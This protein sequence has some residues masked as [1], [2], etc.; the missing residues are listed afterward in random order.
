MQEVDARA[1]LGLST[2]SQK[3]E[4]EAAC[5]ARVAELRERLD[6]APDSRTRNRLETRFRGVE[7][8]P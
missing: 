2:G 6:Q 5:R 4:I 8:S 1:V 3:S 7:R